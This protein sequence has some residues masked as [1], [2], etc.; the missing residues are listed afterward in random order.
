[1]NAGITSYWADHI[2]QQVAGIEGDNIGKAIADRLP[3]SFIYGD[4]VEDIINDLFKAGNYKNLDLTKVPIEA[5][6]KIEGFSGEYKIPIKD[7]TPFKGNVVLKMNYNIE[8]GG[9]DNTLIEVGV[10]SIDGTY[11]AIKPESILKYKI[12]N[13]TF[14]EIP[15]NSV[16]N[17]KLKDITVKIIN[18]FDLPGQPSQFLADGIR[19]GLNDLTRFTPISDKAHDDIQD[20]L[21]DMGLDEYLGNGDY[22]KIISEQLIERLPYIG[23]AISLAGLSDNIASVINGI[24]GTDDVISKA[25]ISNISMIISE[26]STIDSPFENIIDFEDKNALEK[27]IDELLIFSYENNTDFSPQIIGGSSTDLGKENILSISDRFKSVGPKG[28]VKNSYGVDSEFSAEV[29]IA[30]YNNVK[31]YEDAGLFLRANDFEIGEAALK[32]YYFAISDENNTAVIGYFDN[33]FYPLTSAP[34]NIESGKWYKIKAKA[35]G[36]E[37]SFYV[38]DMSNPIVTTKDSRY[39]SGVMPV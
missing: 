15:I 30:N 5:D 39:K 14:Y 32:G 36:E 29:Y 38:D 34:I 31:S 35:V 4:T 2:L 16:D 3:G 18:K 23:K 11:T 10:T 24:I 20:M 19:D 28:V 33:K 1:M 7:T 22:G 6:N 12:E 21:K 13:D 27:N 26:V 17:L 37:L 25:K 8:S 9:R